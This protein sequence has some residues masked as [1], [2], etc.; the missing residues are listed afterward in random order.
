MKAASL[1]SGIG[2]FELGLA[3]SGFEPVLFCDILPTAQAVLAARFPGVA[4][5]PDVTR[6]RRLPAGLTLVSAG[7]PCQDLSQAG[8]TAGLAGARS[9]LVGEVFRLLEDARV[10]ARPVPWVVI[11]NVAFMLQLSS[12]SAMRVI[13]EAFE[14]MGYRWAWRVVDTYGF[15]L[16]QRRERVYFVACHESMIG[17]AKHAG[18]DPARVLLVDDVPIARAQTR[19]GQIGHGFYWTEGFTG[20]GWAPGA[21]P[22]LKNGSSVGIASPPAVLLPDGRIVKPTI[23]AME[24]LQGFPDDWTEPAERVARH[25]LWYSLVGNAVSVP[26]PRWVGS[27]VRSPGEYDVARDGAFPE[28]GRLPRAARF[29]GHKRYAVSIGTDPLGLLP[30]SIESVLA[31]DHEPLSVRATSGFLERA[32]RGRM[33][34]A[35]GFLDAVEAH[36]ERMRDADS[37]GAGRAA[38]K[39]DPKARAKSSARKTRRT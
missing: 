4:I 21:V 32:R 7:F 10:R 34:F 18:V 12:G 1:F 20:L 16:P 3:C 19:L 38:P 23:R 33:R 22:T 9:G 14:R 28:T 35:P 11:E 30:P 5:A 36:L 37:K 26:V 24:R 25:S 31:G 8:K 15:G 17:R 13:I 27:R 6:L 29:D 2:G 39:S